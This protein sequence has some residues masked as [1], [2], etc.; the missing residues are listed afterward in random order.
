[1]EFYKSQYIAVTN[2]GKIA[3]IKKIWQQPVAK[4]LSDAKNFIVALV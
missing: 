2:R 3:F 1:M 4:S